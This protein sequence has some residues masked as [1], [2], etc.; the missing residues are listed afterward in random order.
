MVSRDAG[1]DRLAKQDFHLV[2]APIFCPLVQEF[3]LTITQQ[4]QPRL[5]KKR[6]VDILVFDMISAAATGFDILRPT[7]EL[8]VAQDRKAHVAVNH[9]TVV[10]ADALHDWCRIVK[11]GMVTTIGL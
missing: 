10:D 3:F 11:V 5:I 6:R 1:K 7:F 8:A 9:V 4:N 2:T